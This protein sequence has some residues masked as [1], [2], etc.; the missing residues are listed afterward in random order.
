L[1]ATSEII[2]AVCAHFPTVQAIYLYGSFGAPNARPDSDIDIGL[3][4]SHEE[5][6]AAGGLAMHPLR[7]DLEDALRREID[8]VN[9]RLADTVLCKEVVAK[10][11]RIYCADENA[12]DAFE[13][14]TLSLYQKLN[15]ERADIVADFPNWGDDSP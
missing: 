8:L 4:F 12:A 3:L 1:D 6:K 13:M 2:A 14:Y 11:R 5:A 15:E 7:T 9:L 10:E